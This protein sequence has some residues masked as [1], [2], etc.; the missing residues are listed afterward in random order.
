MSNASFGLSAIT[1]TPAPHAQ[2]AGFVTQ[3]NGSSGQPA[4]EGAKGIAAPVKPNAL[5]NAGTAA[6]AEAGGQ[7]LTRTGTAEQ[8]VQAVDRINEL[9][10]LGSHA[11]KFEINRDAERLVVQVVDA[12]TDEVI[13]QIPS[14]ETL[15]FAEYVEGLAGLIFNDQA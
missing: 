12:S 2:P 7:D 11:V 9:M 14:E 15:K 4:D 13:R 6:R 1:P 3:R 5:E 8:V 10:Q